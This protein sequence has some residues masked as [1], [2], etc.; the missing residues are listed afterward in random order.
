MRGFYGIGLHMPKTHHNVAQALR[1]AF[2]YDANFVNISGERYSRS[3]VDTTRADKH[4]PVFDGLTS[5]IDNRPRGSVLISVEI[6][7][8][9]FDLRT[10]CH[11]EQALYIFGPE[12]GSIPNH[13]LDKSQCK[14]KIPTK[15]CMNLAATV[16]VLLYDRIQKNGK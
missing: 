7:D 15:V 5:V 9:A 1:A 14:V 3:S 12:D 10:F 13:I 16:N 2:C 8:D 6:T 11:P 4:I